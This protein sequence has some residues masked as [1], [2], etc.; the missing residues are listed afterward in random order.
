ML[1]S[2]PY[3]ETSALL[4]F[5]TMEHGL[6]RVMGKG[7][8]GARARNKGDLQPFIPL[9]IS[10]RGR[11]ELKTLTQFEVVGDS[12]TPMGRGMWCALY[13]HELLLYLVKPTLADPELF[14]AY[15]QFLLQLKHEVAFTVALRQFEVALLD[16]LGLPPDLGVYNRE[17]VDPEQCYTYSV[18][19]GLVPLLKGQAVKTPISGRAVLALLARNFDNTALAQEA[20]LILAPHI[21]SLLGGKPLRS[22]EMW[23]S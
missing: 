5:L 4:D 3:R 21:Q 9:K 2:R 15:N 1:H 14:A 7:V 11:S 19:D 6:V 18:H 23:K 17:P 22:R 20:R 12:L 8:R 16:S 13:V 10:V